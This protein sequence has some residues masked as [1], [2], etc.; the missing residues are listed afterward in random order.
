MGIGREGLPLPLEACR[1]LRVLHVYIHRLCRS[2]LRTDQHFKSCCANT[3][4]TRLRALDT[5]RA[6]AHSTGCLSELLLRLRCISALWSRKSNDRLV[7]PHGGSPSHDRGALHHLSSDCTDDRPCHRVRGI[8][9]HEPTQ[10]GV[11][12]RCNDRAGRLERD[13]RTTFANGQE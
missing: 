7:P 6:G 9:K 10:S 8:A 1:H 4:G 2:T 13:H 5:H 3:A 11:V 12:S